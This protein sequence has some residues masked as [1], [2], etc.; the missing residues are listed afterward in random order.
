MISK[1]HIKTLISCTKL[2]ND[3]KSFIVKI[4][5]VITLSILSYDTQQHSLDRYFWFFV[6]LRCEMKLQ[7]G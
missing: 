3:T 1:S 6:R 2:R 4:L 5:W 7:G